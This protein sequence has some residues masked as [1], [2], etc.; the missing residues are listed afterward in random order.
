MWFIRRIDILAE[1]IGSR[2]RAIQEAIREQGDVTRNA[3][4]VGNAANREVAGVI[5]SAIHAANS[6]VPEYEKEQRNREYRLQRK[7]FWATVGA[8]IAAVVYAG[9]AAYQGRLMRQTYME[10]RKQTKAAERSAYVSCVNAQVAQ[11]TLTQVQNGTAY[12]RAMAQAAAEQ[13]VANVDLNR[14]LV[15]ITASVPSPD[16]EIGKDFTVPYSV[17]NEGKAAA[18]SLSF[19]LTGILVMPGES[20]RL[21]ERQLGKNTIGRIAGETQIPEKPSAT[22]KPAIP[23]FM[24]RDIAGNFVPYPSASTQQFFGQ[25]KGTIFIFGHTTYADF[26]GSHKSQFCYPLWLMMANTT[27]PGKSDAN[28]L[29]C[30][31]YNHTPDHY[32]AP[33]IESAMPSSQ[34]TLITCQPPK[35]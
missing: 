14:A 32:K 25:G 21:D 26:T 19:W 6:D 16:Q 30:A 33:D 2:L 15:N 23:M 31:K 22:T 4:D 11:A 3:A 8:G 35:D 5:A 18:V 24:V 28:E 9:I 13:T 10:I 12:S 34:I 7:L 20:L 29:L 17:I 1:T 27:R